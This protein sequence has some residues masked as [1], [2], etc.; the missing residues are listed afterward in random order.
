MPSQMEGQPVSGPIPEHAFYGPEAE[1]MP[2]TRKAS[3]SISMH[4]TALRE[5]CDVYCSLK[6][7]HLIL[8]C[9]IMALLIR[10][11]NSRLHLLD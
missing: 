3:T 9:E 2:Q 5:Q 10:P 7:Q 8:G 1:A 11:C 4:H 6:S